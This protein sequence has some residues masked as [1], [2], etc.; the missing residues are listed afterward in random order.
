MK[1]KK[2][3]MKPLLGV[4][5]TMKPDA[6]FIFFFGVGLI[7]FSAFMLS[8]FFPSLHFIWEDPPEGFIEHAGLSIMLVFCSYFGYVYCVRLPRR[9]RTITRSFTNAR[10]EAVKVY[11]S[12]VS[13]NTLHVKL[14]RID[15]DKTYETDNRKHV[16]SKKIPRKCWIEAL[17][18]FDRERELIAFKVGTELCW[19]WGRWFP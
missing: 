1:I 16:V 6:A 13:K 5:H 4:H 18:Y 15:G 17:G 7:A 8:G 19:I 11:I 9:L 14:R 12:R 10:P 3:L 2:L